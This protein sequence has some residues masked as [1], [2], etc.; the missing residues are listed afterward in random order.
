MAIAVDDDESG[1][2]LVIP[3]ARRNRITGW[4]GLAAAV[5]AT[6]T[7]AWLHTKLQTWMLLFSLA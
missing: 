7:L 5:V 4:T 3:V 6:V 2:Q 1:V